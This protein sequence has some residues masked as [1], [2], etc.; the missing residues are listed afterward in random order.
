MS[1]SWKDQ[2]QKKYDPHLHCPICGR[3]MPPDRKFCSQD[4]KDNYLAEQ[5]KS[6]KKNRWQMVCL[7]GMVVVM[8]V[9]TIVFPMLGG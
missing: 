4:C 5:K 2:I 6:K 7:V 1:P 8:I 9:F 3:A